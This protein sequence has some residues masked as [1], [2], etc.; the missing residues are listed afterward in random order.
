MEKDVRKEVMSKIDVTN[1]IERIVAF[2]ERLDVTIESISA[3][4]DDDGTDSIPLKICGELIAKNGEE[5]S[6]NIELVTAVY[7]VQDRIISKDSEYFNKDN[8]FGLEIFQLKMFL[9][10]SE[11]SK[12][13][14]YPKKR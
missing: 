6:Q 9:P 3:F 7:D 4:L 11:I 2:E 1:K 8:F 5:L 12:I 10:V 14:I 13:K